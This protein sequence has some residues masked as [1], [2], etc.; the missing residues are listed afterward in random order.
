MTSTYSTRDE[1]IQSEIIDAIMAGDVDS[2]E[3]Y[4][5]EAI[6]DEVL[7]DYST[8]YACQVT[9]EEFWDS[10]QRHEVMP[11]TALA[12][13]DV[14]TGILTVTP[15]LEGPGGGLINGTTVDPWGED[16]MTMGRA[17][18]AL[19]LINLTRITDWAKYPHNDQL[20]TARV[21]VE[22]GRPRG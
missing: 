17:D 15:P 5:V 2:I 11:G 6:A 21:E 16:E 1:A 7:G 12:S 22:S 3:E 10:V 13:M 4:D 8:G 14:V 19:I 18:D 20:W 9:V